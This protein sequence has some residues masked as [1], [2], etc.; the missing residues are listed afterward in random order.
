MFAK[1]HEG[2][3]KPDKTQGERKVKIGG[4]RV[5]AGVLPERPRKARVAPAGDGETEL[6]QIDMGPPG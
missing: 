3:E 6:R 1:L 5:S 2:F 4:S